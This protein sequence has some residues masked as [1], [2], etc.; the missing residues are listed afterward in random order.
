[1]TY[2]N[3][4][5]SNLREC[6][7]YLKHLDNIND[8]SNRK[9]DFT[10]VMDMNYHINTIMNCM[11]AEKMEDKSALLKDIA[12]K[13]KKESIM[14]S[15]FGSL[16]TDDRANY[17]TWVS[18]KLKIL[19]GEIKTELNYPEINFKP[20]S[21]K[22]RTNCILSIID[23]W[24]VKKEVKLSMIDAIK[25]N[26]SLASNEFKLPFKWLD[27]K[28]IKQCNFAYEYTTNFFKENP[29]NKSYALNY[30][31]PISAHEKYES[32]IAIF[33]FWFTHIEAKKLFLVNIN[34]AWNQKKHREEVKNKKNALN[35]YINKDAK[36]C[37]DELT[38]IHNKK[39][40][41]MIEFLIYKELENL[42]NNNN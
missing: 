18:L 10:S 1:M 31:T 22:D 41:E 39:I 15:D 26:F 32:I 7:F 16:L 12:M 25:N 42:K 24:L 14:E 11:R 8:I 19:N 9:I 6:R 33:D 29:H 36:K 17:Y 5:L 21:T 3:I 38:K 4:Q 13:Y 40:N 35:T 27:K 34:K 37:L 20:S 2:N 30:L 23:A 28:N